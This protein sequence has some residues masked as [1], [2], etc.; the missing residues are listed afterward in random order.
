MARPLHSHFRWIVA[1]VFLLVVG[2]G[3]VASAKTTERSLV[4]GLSFDRWTADDGLPVNHVQNLS[5]APDGRVWVATFNGLARL[6]G[7]SVEPFRQ[8][9]HLGLSSSRFTSVAV[10]EDWGGLG[11]ER[12]G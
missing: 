3:S 4:R 5:I 11:R 2:V 9:T 6:D 7:S 8:G 12:G 1:W 10:A